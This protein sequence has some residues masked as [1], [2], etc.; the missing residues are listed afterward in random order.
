MKKQ[1]FLIGV[2]LLAALQGAEACS[3]ITFVGQNGEVLTGRTMDWSTDDD[4][5]M[6]VMARNVVRQSVSP[7]QPL[8]WKSKYGSVI[9]VSFGQSLNSGMNE[10]GL[11]VDSLWLG[12]TNYGKPS[13]DEKTV[14]ANEFVLYLLDNFTSV[15][16]AVDALKA[17]GVRIHQDKVPGTDMDLK[18]HFM[19]TDKSG[20]NAVLEYLDGKLVVHEKQGVAAMTNDPAYDK[21][22]AIE[23]VYRDRGLFQNMPGSP[24]AV[25][26]Y[27][28]AVGWTDRIAADAGDTDAS[29]PLDMKVL[30]IMRTVSSPL[31][32]SNKDN[33]ENCTTLWRA[34]A[35]TKNASLTVDSAFGKTA[36]TIRLGDLSFTQ[37]KQI[38]RVRDLV[39]DHAIDVTSTVR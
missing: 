33:P 11:V 31:G 19:I 28:R 5:T 37:D 29:I 16:E 13:A 4:V 25:D 26:R 21:M 34:V 12:D 39:R 20:A 38:I 17:G 18:L 6:R 36:V 24:A 15:R 35:D 9:V 2:S 14:G 30:S 27:L 32:L 1:L 7:D 3:R 23:K 10:K 22:Q 8:Q